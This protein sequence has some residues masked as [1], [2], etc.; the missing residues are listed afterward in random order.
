MI[1]SAACYRGHMVT[2]YVSDGE[3]FEDWSLDTNL[4]GEAHGFRL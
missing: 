1:W 4:G 2:L 3:D